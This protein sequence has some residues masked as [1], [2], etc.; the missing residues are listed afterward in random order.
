[1]S[2]LICYCFQYTELDIINDFKTNNGKSSILA[3]ITEARIRHTCQCDDKHPEKRCC[4]ADV[5]R[6]VDNITE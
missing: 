6:V 3:G 5:R 1:M 2:R 4:I